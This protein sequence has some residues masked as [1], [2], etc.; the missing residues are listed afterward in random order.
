MLRGG[1]T[2]RELGPADT[3]G[4]LRRPGVRARHT[5]SGLGWEQ[6]YLSAQQKQPYRGVFDPAPTHLL[7]VHLDGPVTVRRERGG[8][9]RTR[10]VPA[11]A[12]IPEPDAETYRFHPF[13]LTKV[14]SKKD[15]PL[16]EVG[17]F[18]LNSNPDNYFADVEQA[19]FTPTNLVP[20][21]SYSPDKMLQ[22]RLF[23][24]GD[25]A[26]YRLGVN[27]HQVPVNCPRA[28]SW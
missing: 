19:A 18:E 26:R 23:S 27:H 13:D 20:G 21:I 5:S 1:R 22:G 4:I 16:I 8:G 3:V 17:E 9:A 6:L 24:Y 7:I 14:W 25:A 28:Q 2:T 12:L 15:Y 10:T 11:G